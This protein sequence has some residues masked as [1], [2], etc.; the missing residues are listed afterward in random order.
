MGIVV[1]LDHTRARVPQL[2]GHDWQRHAIHDS[3]RSVGMA[4]MVKRDGRVNLHRPACRNRY[5][6]LA[7][8]IAGHYREANTDQTILKRSCNGDLGRRKAPPI[9]R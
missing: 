1:A 3:A 5:S 2:R 8:S 7:Q 6:L 9:A 4:Q